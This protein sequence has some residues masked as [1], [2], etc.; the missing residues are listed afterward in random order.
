MEIA[1]SLLDEVQPP[2]LND[3]ILGESEDFTELW[4]ID[5]RLGHLL[6]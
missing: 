5:F 6:S 1:D 3:I 2:S 4:T